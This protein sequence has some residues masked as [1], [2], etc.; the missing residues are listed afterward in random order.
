[1]MLLDPMPSYTQK[2]SAGGFSRYNRGIHGAQHQSALHFWL[3]GVGSVHRWYTP[4]SQPWLFVCG[5]RWW[6]PWDEICQLHGFVICSFLKSM[7]LNMALL[8]NIPVGWS[9]DS[10]EAGLCAWFPLISSMTSQ[11]SLSGQFSSFFPARKNKGVKKIR[12]KLQ[13]CWAK[14]YVSSHFGSHLLRLMICELLADLSLD[15][16]SFCHTCEWCVRS[17]SVPI[18]QLVTRPSRLPCELFGPEGF[19]RSRATTGTPPWDGQARVPSHESRNCWR[20][21][22][23]SMVENSY[24][25]W[26]LVMVNYSWLWLV[27]LCYV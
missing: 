20:T 21:G 3:V 18:S 2:C 14:Q 1:M 23:R 10:V 27:M 22:I 8:Q 24:G 15:S 4:P 9:C 17:L 25:C 5:K 11:L 7:V 13:F 6:N 19:A 12:W 26:W 16:C